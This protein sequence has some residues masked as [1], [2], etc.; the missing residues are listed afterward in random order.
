MRNLY[1]DRLRG[2][3]TLM[4]VLS[5]ASGYVPLSFFG[6]PNSLR[7]SI[8]AN[9]YS[10]V[11][12]FFAVS[13]FLITGKALSDVDQTGSF[14]VKRF[15]VH[16]AAR[17]MPGLLLM[18]VCACAISLAAPKLFEFNW[19]T[20][21]SRIWHILTF[22]YNIYFTTAGGA[23]RVWDPLWSLSVEEIFYLCFPITFLSENRYLFFIVLFCL[24]IVGPLH[25]LSTNS[26]YAYLSNF[27]GIAMGAIAA[28]VANKFK[29]IE[30]RRFNLTL[31]RYVGASIIAANFLY[32]RGGYGSPHASLTWGP[33]IMGT[34][35]AIYLLGSTR[36]NTIRYTAFS[37]LEKFGQYSY[38]IYLFHMFLLI[39]LT[40]IFYLPLP[41]VD[42]NLHKTLGTVWMVAIIWTLLAAAH[43]IYTRYSEPARKAVAGFTIKLLTGFTKRDRPPA[44][45]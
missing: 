40:N 11:S 7:Y 34:G 43:I 2:L 31:L 30:I 24:I 27:D 26:A 36:S 10:G 42:D 12:I 29:N 32:T 21:P 9:G 39:S 8:S 13:G 19:Q 16:R 41:L 33:T 35:A 37:W 20:A 23:S 22:R 3:A 6:L 25:R 17:I 15:Y 38:E 44:L 4:V 28:L 45:E 18:I 14:S 1:V 5:H